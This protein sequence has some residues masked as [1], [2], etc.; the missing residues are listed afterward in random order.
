[1]MRIKGKKYALLTIVFALYA[2]GIGASFICLRG[3]SARQ[4][5]A[6]ILTGAVI[7]W[8]TWENMRLRQTA[9]AQRETQIR[10]FVVVERHG[11]QFT[12]RNLGLGTALNVKVRNV[13]INAMENIAISFPDQITTLAPGEVRAISATSFHGDAPRGDF[14]TAHLDPKFANRELE[15]TVDFQNVEMK[16]LSVALKVGPGKLQIVHTWR[17]VAL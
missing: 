10:P 5:W 6:V 7:I 11:K 13:V 8:Y 16:P 1:M 14:F 9:V 12:V 3:W 4:T 15:I 2:L 17:D